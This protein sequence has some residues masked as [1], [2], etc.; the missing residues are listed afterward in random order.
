[1][2]GVDKRSLAQRAGGG[3]GKAQLQREAARRRGGFSFNTMG[4]SST[5]VLNRSNGMAFSVLKCVRNNNNGFKTSR[6]MD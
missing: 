1:M 4:D 5:A 2:E 6:L 3:R